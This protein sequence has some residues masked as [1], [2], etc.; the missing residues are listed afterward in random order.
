MDRLGLLVK[1]RGIV[2]VAERMLSAAAPAMRGWQLAWGHT[3]RNAVSLSYP[4]KHIYV[5]RHFLP[6]VPTE[7]LEVLDLLSFSYAS[8]NSCKRVY[9]VLVY[10]S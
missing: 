4:L 8:F 1:M 2:E 3:K 5:S 10:S 7:E 6:L 9:F